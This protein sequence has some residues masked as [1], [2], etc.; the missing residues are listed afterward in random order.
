MPVTPKKSK[1][2]RLAIFDID[3]TI[4]RSSLLIQLVN[5]FVARNIFPRSVLKKVENDYLAWVNRRGS[6]ETY[7]WK[8]VEVFMHN[9]GGKRK[10][11]V[12]AAASAVIKEQKDRVYRYTRDL[13]RDLRR[14][15]YYL[16]AVSGSPHEIVESFVATMKFDAAF[17]VLYEIKN[18]VYSGKIFK[19]NSARNKARVISEFLG[20][21]GMR[22]DFKHSY[23]VG[24]TEGDIPSLTLV[25]NPIAF[26]PNQKLMAFATKHNIPIVVER[27]DV[28][29]QLENFSI[30]NKS[31]IR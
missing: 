26:N 9:I 3:G 2:V 19:D 13:I 20:E 29:Y 16:V 23:A 12:V 11:D 10:S 7:I 24:D 6:Y 31:I 28:I 4:F 1:I 18:G 22:A 27:K 8:V 17:G 5:E 14:R 25:G 30:Q 15:G 21:S